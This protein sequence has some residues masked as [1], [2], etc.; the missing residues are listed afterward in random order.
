MRQMLMG[1]VIFTVIMI[2]AVFFEVLKSRN[3]KTDIK[4]LNILKKRSEDYYEQIQ[5]NNIDLQELSAVLEGQKEVVEKL[6]TDE[7]DNR[8]ESESGFQYTGKALLDVVLFRKQR[9]AIAQGIH[10]GIEAEEILDVPWEEDEMVSLFENLL[11]NAVE[12]CDGA[13][14]DGMLRENSPFIKVEI[15]KKEKM[16]EYR[17]CVENTKKEHL[18]PVE[19]HFA[20]SKKDKEHHGNGVAIVQ[21]IVEKYH[22]TIEF[23]DKGESFQVVINM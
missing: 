6:I 20:T 21:N 8:G 10:F 19:N 23:V 12:A 4:K 18:H 7:N 14:E 9:L 22:G 1:L 15:K 11:D 5:N 16:P 17:I 3:L 2:L 13:V